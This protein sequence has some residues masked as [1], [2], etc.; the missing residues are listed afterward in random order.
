MRRALLALVVALGCSHAT[1]V[2]KAGG[3]SSG[4][5]GDQP[6]EH[7]GG[8][9]QKPAAA[10]RPEKPGQPPLAASPSGLIVPGGVEKIQK[11]LSDRGYLD[12][13]QART[14][15][16]DAE[17]AAAIRKFQSDEGIARTGAPDH[18][19]VRRLGLNPDEMFRK[20]SA[21]KESGDSSVK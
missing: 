2:A 14:G 12:S 8:A 16:I 11:A 9:A 18:E 7:Q 5:G 21:V 19:T 10:R 1:N 4:G 3:D 15:D 20:S 13:G 17:T 6:A